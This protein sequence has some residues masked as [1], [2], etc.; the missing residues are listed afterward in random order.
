MV[1][2]RGRRVRLFRDLTFLCELLHLDYGVLGRYLRERG[3]WDGLG[4]S[5]Y[6]VEEEVASRNL[7]KE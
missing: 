7:G 5:V 3:W 4:Y 6:V 2:F 1:I